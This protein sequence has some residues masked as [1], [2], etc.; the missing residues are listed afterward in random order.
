MN[1]TGEQAATHRYVPSLTK[2]GP[3]GRA[4]WVLSV[5]DRQTGKE[6]PLFVSTQS[7]PAHQKRLIILDALL[8]LSSQEF[9]LRWL[10]GHAPESDT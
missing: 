7:A 5:R 6:T 1:K 9:R 8:L 4:L 2:R 3:R 10:S